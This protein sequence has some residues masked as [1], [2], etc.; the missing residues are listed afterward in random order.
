MAEATYALCA[1]TSCVCAFLLLRGYRQTSVRLL[2]WTGL[3]FVGL[4]ANNVLLFVDLI[5]VPNVDLSL[6]RNV[7]AL[8]ALSVLLIGLVTEAR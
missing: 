7:T 8:A 4:T 1:L 6:W 3:C 2:L 5:V